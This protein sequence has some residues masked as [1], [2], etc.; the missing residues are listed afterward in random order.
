MA[1]HPNVRLARASLEAFMRGDVEAMASSL[2]DDVVWH[3]PGVHRFAGEFRGRDEVVDRFR[4]MAAAGVASVIEEIHD[5]V[6]NDEHVVA[7]VILRIDAPEGS[8]P[9]RSVQVMHV[10][11]GR[12]VQFWSMNDRQDEIDHVIG[13]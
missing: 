12:V 7:L 2:A 13:R 9:T 1:E 10:V 11:D 3:A 5:V 8:V 4:R 6:G